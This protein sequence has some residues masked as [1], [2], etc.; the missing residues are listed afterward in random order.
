MIVQDIVS[1]HSRDCEFVVFTLYSVSKSFLPS[2]W[3]QNAESLY[4]DQFRINDS[5]LATEASEVINLVCHEQGLGY[6]KFAKSVI[7]MVF[8]PLETFPESFQLSADTY[9]QRRHVI[10]RKFLFI[11]GP[12]IPVLLTLNLFLWQVSWNS[13]LISRTFLINKCMYMRSNCNE[14]CI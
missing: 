5:L 4:W 12:V 3:K 6:P 2:L 14:Q 9:N 7:R 10:P 8:K 11:A 1:G 13:S